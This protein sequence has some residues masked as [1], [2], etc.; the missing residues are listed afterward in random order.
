MVALVLAGCGAEELATTSAA[1]VTTPQT[2]VVDSQRDS[3]DAGSVVVF[4]LDFAQARRATSPD[5]PQLDSVHPLP[6]DLTGCDPANERAYV[7]AMGPLRPRD[8][9]HVGAM[10]VVLT[11]ANRAPDAATRL[12]FGVHTAAGWA[13][14]WTPQP[15]AIDRGGDS[16][17]EPGAGHFD[18]AVDTDGVDAVA[19]LMAHGQEALSQIRYTAIPATR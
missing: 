13:W 6:G 11:N 7:A 15:I 4:T 12:C 16:L 2:F 1:P 18:L 14:R 10:Q 19:L 9:G 3:I 8:T 17:G 5:D